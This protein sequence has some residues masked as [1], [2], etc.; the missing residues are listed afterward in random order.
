MVGTQ[1]IQKFDPV[2]NPLILKLPAWRLVNRLTLAI[3]EAKDFSRGL[4][5]DISVPQEFVSVGTRSVYFHWEFVKQAV[6]AIKKARRADSL[7]DTF[8]VWVVS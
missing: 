4:V 1:N 3:E 7:R 5:L 6:E 8:E 2:V